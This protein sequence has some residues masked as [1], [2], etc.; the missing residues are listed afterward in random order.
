MLVL[1]RYDG[2]EIIIGGVIR[3]VI[4]KIIAGK[5]NKVRIGI[6]APKDITVHRKEI[7]QEFEVEQRLTDSDATPGIGEDFG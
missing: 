4:T 7:Q 5:R 3:V 6:V 2:E 1:S